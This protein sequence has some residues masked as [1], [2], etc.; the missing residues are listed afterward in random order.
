MIYK[1]EI[2]NFHS[3][4]TRQ[5]LD[6]RAP[7]NAPNDTLRLAPC[8]QGSRERAP[9]VVAVFGANGSGKSNLLRALSFVSWFV[10]S[11][12]TLAANARIPH[13]PFN[14]N[15]SFK[16][17]TRLRLWLSARKV[18]DAT[19]NDDGAEC[20][21]C[22]ELTIGNGDNRNVL[23][24]SI[25][26]WPTSSGRKTRLIERFGRWHCQSGQGLWPVRVQGSSRKDPTAKCKCYLYSRSTQSSSC[27]QNSIICKH[28]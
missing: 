2:E 18:L 13:E 5:V 3:I 14:D 24:E 27:I 6:L 20:P 23:S 10:G 16:E 7:A 19:E 26:Y 11:S 22:Y 25:F 21:Y 8:W 12:F 28:D 17:A 1:I 15:A 9:K 4:R